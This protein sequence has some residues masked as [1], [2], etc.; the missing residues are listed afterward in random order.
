MLFGAATFPRGVMARSVVATLVAAEL[1]DK[2]ARGAPDVAHAGGISLEVR[3]LPEIETSA[4]P[5]P[6]AFTP[7]GAC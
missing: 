4:T 2:N 1:G 7:R 3:N 5:L 6:S